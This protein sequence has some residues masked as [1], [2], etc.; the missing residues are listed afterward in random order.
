LNLYEL[1][2]DTFKTILRMFNSR[3]DTAIHKRK[4]LF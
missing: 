3:E 4:R 2:I 1:A